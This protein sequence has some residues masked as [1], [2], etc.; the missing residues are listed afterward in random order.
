M[1]NKHTD[2]K[3]DDRSK[4][5]A[6]VERRTAL[7]KAL[8]VVLTAA[9]VLTMSPLGDAYATGGP[10]ADA[11]PQDAAQ[12]VTGGGLVNSGLSEDGSSA[13]EPSAQASPDAA[14][15]GAAPGFEAEA[16]GAL[17][18]AP[19]AF[20]TWLDVAR[21]VED[22]TLAEE[23]FKPAGTGSEDDPYTISTPR[24]SPG[25]RFCTPTPP[26]SWRPTSI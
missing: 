6:H 16:D 13:D 20:A 22:G 24:P 23:G 17:P 9:L 3:T 12:D 19:T 26:P 18:E 5:R 10:S 11:V 15:E 25:G 2:N 8:S 21:G 4:P 1:Q 7:D 14:G